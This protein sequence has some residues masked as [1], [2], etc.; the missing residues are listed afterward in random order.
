MS[1][2]TIGEVY[3]RD[4]LSIYQTFVAERQYTYGVLYQEPPG[5]WY[6]VSRGLAD[7]SPAIVKLY[8]LLDVF[9]YILYATL[10]FCSSLCIK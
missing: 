10:E 3:G 2:E 1:A 7:S 5:S 8:Y 6:I 9:Q 4:T